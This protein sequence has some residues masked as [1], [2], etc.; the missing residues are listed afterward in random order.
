MQ[1]MVMVIYNEAMDSEVMEVLTHCAL[2]NY[3]KIMGVFG[4]GETSGTH[5][6]DDIWPGKNN[7]LYIAC[8]Q[9][10]A[11]QLLSFVRELRKK[12][13]HEGVKAFVLPIEEAT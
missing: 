1:K 4:K 9:S 6:G 3:T 2:K 7:I 12:L 5:M 8:E 10:E 13:G 11:K